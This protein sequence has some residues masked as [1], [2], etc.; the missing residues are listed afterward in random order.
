MDFWEYNAYQL[1]GGLQF[2]HKPTGCGHRKQGM[3]GKVA[4]LEPVNFE[5]FQLSP[6]QNKNCLRCGKNKEHP[7]QSNVTL[8][9]S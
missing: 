6:Y 1:L 9:I 2:K 4:L 3:V 5:L 8:F 7:S